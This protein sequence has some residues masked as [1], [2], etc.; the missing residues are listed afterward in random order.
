MSPVAGHNL[1]GGTSLAVIPARGGTVR[2]PGKNIADFD[3]HPAIARVISIARDSGVFDHIAVSTD[4]QAIA[5]CAEDAGA[6]VVLRPKALSDGITP[7]Q[8]VVVHAMEDYPDSDFVC[9]LLATAVLLRPERLAVAMALL[10]GNPD[11]D[12]A[13]GVRRFDSPPQ[14]GLLLNAQGFVS[15]QSPQFFS[16]RSQDLEPMYHDAGQFSF[17]RREA[18]LSGGAS[19]MMRTKGIVLPR[20]EAID[21]DEPQD[22]DFARLVFRARTLL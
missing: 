9:L 20:D 3:G 17:G 22:L 4:D 19:F 8:P 21:I 2:V 18:W 5:I 1:G 14:R 10:G 15:M 6:E 12:Y 13:I 7:L 11:L 16:A